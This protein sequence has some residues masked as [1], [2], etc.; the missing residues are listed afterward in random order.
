MCEKTDKEK[1]NMNYKKKY[2]VQITD[3]CTT[4]RTKIYIRQNKIL[5]LT[6]FYDLICYPTKTGTR[7]RIIWQ[8]LNFSATHATF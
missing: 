7:L 3:T 2:Q 1:Q 8:Y 5:H 6:K 4:S